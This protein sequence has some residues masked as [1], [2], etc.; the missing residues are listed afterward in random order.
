MLGPY[1][2]SGCECHKIQFESFVAPPWR[3][4]SSSTDNAF[5]DMLER[6]DE[7]VPSTEWRA[8]AVDFVQFIEKGATQLANV[9]V[10]SVPG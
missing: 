5:W 1:R 10:G 8:F 3:S 6:S 2:L 7:D 4:A 9:V